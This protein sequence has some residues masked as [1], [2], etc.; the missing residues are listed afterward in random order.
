MTPGP[1]SA[2]RSTTRLLVTCASPDQA[3]RVRHLVQDALD[4]S[5]ASAAILPVPVAAAPA[6]PP[7]RHKMALVMLVSVYPTITLLLWLMW[8]LVV[9]LPLFVRT[10]AL[11][12]IMVPV[13]TWLVVPFVT[14]FFMPW[15]AGGPLL[16]RFSRAKAAS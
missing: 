15:L 7:P 16:P 3:E 12:L 1:N 9:D 10:L 11:S 4:R 5:D 13:M 8:P 14:R 6:G 2:D